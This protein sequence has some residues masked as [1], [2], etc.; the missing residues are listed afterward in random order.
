[1]TRRQPADS[2]S[3][4]MWAICSTLGFAIPQDTWDRSPGAE[5]KR[6]GGNLFIRARLQFVRTLG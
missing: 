5:P 2:T 4:A 3:E 6:Q 1:M